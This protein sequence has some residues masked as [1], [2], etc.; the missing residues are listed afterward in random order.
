MYYIVHYFKITSSPEVAATPYSFTG[1]ALSGAPEPQEIPRD[2]SK[3]REIKFE[4]DFS[5]IRYNREEHP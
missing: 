4:R 2:M 1:C 5:V 3:T